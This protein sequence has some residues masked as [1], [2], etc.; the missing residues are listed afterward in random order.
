MLSAVS[1]IIN[2][3]TPRERRAGYSVGPSGHL[4]SCLDC[5]GLANLF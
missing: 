2:L 5:L 4:E 1:E 3:L